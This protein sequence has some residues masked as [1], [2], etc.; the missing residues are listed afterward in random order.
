MHLN[1]RERLLVALGSALGSNCVPCI[2]S[3]LPKARAAQI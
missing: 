1:Q 2:E 3:I